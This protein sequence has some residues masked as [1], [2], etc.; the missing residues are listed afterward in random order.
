[1]EYVLSD[2]IGLIASTLRSLV[3][4]LAQ[5][6]ASRRPTRL[7][8]EY[9]RAAADTVLA[10]ESLED[11]SDRL[12]ALVADEEFWKQELPEAPSRVRP[13]ADLDENLPPLDMESLCAIL[14]ATSARKCEEGWEALALSL[15]RIKKLLTAVQ[16]SL[17]TPDEHPAAS[18]RETLFDA[19]YDTPMPAALRRSLA[20][21]L[22]MLVCT[23]VIGR[24][25]ENGR[26]LPPWL[27][28]GLATCWAE[29][30]VRLAM[31]LGD[32]DA[33]IAWCTKAFVEASELQRVQQALLE[34]K[35]QACA[36]DS[37]IYFPLA[38][39]DREVH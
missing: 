38:G 6:S 13:A 22:R 2:P 3:G 12:D 4:L 36:E 35:Q 7:R 24:A 16:R 14:G 8:S 39:I 23:C 21:V 34:W 27:A 10:A 1:M 28:L 26:K 25:E 19:V 37:P 31:M 18:E 29:A 17:P 9:A 30:P 11:L 15:K 5:S 32:T 33:L 20:A